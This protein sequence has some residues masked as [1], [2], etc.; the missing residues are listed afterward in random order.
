V[1]TAGGVAFYGYI[2]K[3]RTEEAPPLP[4][5]QTAVIT[6]ISGPVYVIRNNETIPAFP[7]EE[8]QPGD[9]V[10]VTEGA[11]A[12]VQL[13]DKGSALLGSDTLVR[14]MKLTGADQKLDLRTEILT[15]SLSYKVEKLDDSE[16]ITIEA[17]GTEY[18]VRGTE[19]V[20]EKNED[21]TVLVVGEGKVQVTGKVDGGE[22]SVGPDEQL[23]IREGED[24]AKV[25]EI[26]EE[27]RI[28]LASAAHLPAMPFGFEDA[29]NPVLVEIVT[30][31]PD[32]DIYIDGLKTGIGRFRGLLPEGTVIDIRVRRRGF[33]D[34]SF[35]LYANS[36]QYIEIQLEPSDLVETL[37]QKKPENPQLERLRTD[38]EQR[39]TE[40][41]LSFADRS[42][43]DAEAKA[44]EQTRIARVRAEREAQL[45]A[46]LEL[47]KAR[48]TVLQ[49][50]L[51]DSRSENQ[52]L[53][54]LIQQIQELTDD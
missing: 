52:K 43:L 38:Y 26:N 23:V 37:A 39:L 33:S 31:P 4:A 6:H 19:F 27:N 15:G 36:D 35:E 48:G 47:V 42:N 50:E 18:E 3:P 16:N 45:A 7:G 21:G 11:V 34:Y 28:R 51:A 49:T 20:I 44:E 2:S 8:L 1:I 13:A 54:E 10:K 46:E 12:Q 5:K 22:V 40:M 17:D 24:P 9:I 14:F 32:S 41:Q 29:P 53:K 30:D 25:E